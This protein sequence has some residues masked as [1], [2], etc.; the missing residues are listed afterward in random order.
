MYVFTQ[1]GQI[2]FCSALRAAI[3]YSGEINTTN[4]VHALR[5]ASMLYYTSS[6]NDKIV[7]PPPTMRASDSHSWPL[8]TYYLWYALRA[9]RMLSNNTKTSKFGYA[10]RVEGS[11][12]KATFFNT[13]SK[14]H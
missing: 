1:I 7:T 13:T 12:Y 9:A 4:V 14:C 10:L 6:S 2:D 8:I 5:A 3:M 11:Y